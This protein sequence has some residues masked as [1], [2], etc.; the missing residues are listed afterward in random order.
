MKIFDN[1]RTYSI[2]EF[3]G[4]VVKF[5]SQI[6]HQ[7][8]IQHESY[9]GIM[10]DR[11][12]EMVASIYSV[13]Y[14]ECAYVPVDTSW[15]ESRILECFENANVKF[16]LTDLKFKNRV[17]NL[18]FTAIV[19]N[20]SFDSSNSNIDQWRISNKK[21]PAYVL[22]TSGST[23]KPKGVVIPQSAVLNLVSYIQKRYPLTFSDSIMF[24][25]PYTFDGSIWEIFA[26][27]ESNA[28]LYVAPVGMEKDPE[29]LLNAIHKHRISFIFFVPAMLNSFLDYLSIADINPQESFPNLKWISVG[30]ETLSVQLVQKFYE[31]I[32]FNKT[33]LINVYGPT[34]TTVYATTYL[35]DPN[36]K[37][38]K[39][40]I[41]YPVD[42][43][44]IYILK[45]NLE[46][47]KQGE[48]GEIFI[49]GEGVALGY[50]NREELTAERFIPDHIKGQGIMYRTGDIGVESTPGIFDFI[51][52][53]DFQVKIRGYRM[54]M[55]EIEYAINNLPYI[56]EAVAIAVK[57]SNNQGV[58]LCF[59]IIEQ[60]TITSEDQQKNQMV[61]DMQRVLP[62]YMIP[63]HIFFV[64][65]FPLSENGKVDR[66]RL[67]NQYLSINQTPT[68]EQNTIT[69]F[70][71]QNLEII[72][73]QCWSYVLDLS[74]D[75]IEKQ[76]ESTFFEL[77]GNS[78]KSIQLIVLIKK[79]IRYKTINRRTISKQHFE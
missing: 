72:L 77:G 24:K 55:G 42:N 64:K 78:I 17:E 36:E 34:E 47:A 6:K 14:L 73:T 16:V 67:S 4:G 68:I 40:P 11:S 39:I 23:G 71:K 25:S 79:E 74:I 60:T 28:N 48:E 52:R 58:L 51:G 27:T 15:P 53:K 50:L 8:K 19:P 70:S 5:A 22:Y 20:F 56:K 59:A 46:L 10:M 43:Y 9:I 66:N 1:N 63:D 21:K 2:N 35:C 57:D 29:Q 54:E 37:L 49:G 62:E 76:R 13:I 65:E 3:G 32:D 7:Y 44:Q 33:K 61:Q 31:H 75:T 38:K 69:D 30:G 12:I 18:G 26:W 41:G 45:E